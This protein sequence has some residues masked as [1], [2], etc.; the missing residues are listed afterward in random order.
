LPVASGGNNIF[1][2][3][4]RQR[5]LD[6]AL[7][8]LLQLWSSHMPDR[9]K[10]GR[11]ISHPAD[12]VNAARALIAPVLLFAPF[13]V[14]WFS[15]YEIIYAIVTFVAIGETN[16]LLHLHIHRPFSRNKVL[17][18]VFDLSMGVVTGMTASNW[19]IQHVYGHHR[20]LD[21]PYRGERSAY[22]QNYSAT[23]A[24]SYSA[25]SLLETFYAPI[26]ESFNKG[27]L[28]NIK[29][30]ISYRWAFFDQML[31][32]GFVA[33]LMAWQPRLVLIYLLPWYFVTQFVTRY[34]DYLNHYGCDEAS[35]DP[36]ERANNSLS[37]WFNFTTHN[38]GYHTA[39]HIRPGAHWTELPGIHKAIAGKI[40][41]R[42]LKPFSW[43]WILMPYHFHRSRTG[44]M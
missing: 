13:A 12:R 19:R 17:N 40:P 11:W 38:F 14:N 39:H 32:V 31:L 9:Q 26:V 5:F 15:G 4:V 44:R 29:T 34:V 6:A 43:S 16:Y 35:A 8:F 36:Y 23:R 22:L 33:I 2:E 30:P 7:E 24:V 20:G 42:H 1:R 3:N 28:D 27:I 21:K 18:I 25:I 10:P 37:W 41:E